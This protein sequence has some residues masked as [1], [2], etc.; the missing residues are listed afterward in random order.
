MINHFVIL[1]GFI[2]IALRTPAM[3]YR[4]IIGTMHSACT[5]Q[6]NCTSKKKYVTCDN[7]KIKIRVTYIT[8]YLITLYLIYQQQHQIIQPSSYI[9]Q[10]RG[11]IEATLT[12]K[13]MPLA[14]PDHPLHSPTQPNI[15]TPNTLSNHTTNLYYANTVVTP[16]GMRGP[17]LY[18]PK[19]TLKPW[20]C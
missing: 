18:T 10:H 2:T 17:T 6:L 3:T 9:Y 19:L 11:C 4:C 20:I 5:I 12:M 7:S 8:F 14:C 16:Y 15:N 1:K 13:W